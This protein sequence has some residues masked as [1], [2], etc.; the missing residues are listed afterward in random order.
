M[1]KNQYVTKKVILDE[2]EIYWNNGNIT[3]K[4]INF[5]YLIARKVAN[6][7]NYFSYVY[8][9]EMIQ[10]A[11]IH[12]ILKGI[13]KFEKNKTNPF[14]YFSVIINHKFM[15]FIKKEKRN[16]IIKEEMKRNILRDIKKSDTNI[17]EK[18]RVDNN[19]GIDYCEK[20]KFDTE[21]NF[22]NALKTGYNIEKKRI[23][24]SKNNYISIIRLVL[25]NLSDNSKFYDEVIVEEIKL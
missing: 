5:I 9:S 6:S 24:L 17:M 7:R 18:C 21:E 16:I 12:V 1:K 20:L 23:R 3:D 14:A 22:W 2:L 25:K 8:K 15:E 4:M 11:V 19:S 10:E 13:P